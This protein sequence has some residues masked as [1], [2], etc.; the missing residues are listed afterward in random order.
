MSAAGGTLTGTGVAVRR[1]VPGRGSRALRNIDVIPMRTVAYRMAEFSGECSV[2]SP[3]AE[4]IAA[5]ESFDAPLCVLL[6]D[7]GPRIHHAMDAPGAGL[8]N[9]RSLARALLSTTD[10][11]GDMQTVRR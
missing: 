5:S 4:A 3:G 2:S 8:S 11:R 1:R 6:G 10:R 7:G 9:R